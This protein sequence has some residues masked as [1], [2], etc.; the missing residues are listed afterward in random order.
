MGPGAT[1]QLPEPFT[2]E[3]AIS[4]MDEAGVRP[5]RDRSAV[6]AWRSQ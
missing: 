2:I 6:L 5:R 3:R 4:M 1:P